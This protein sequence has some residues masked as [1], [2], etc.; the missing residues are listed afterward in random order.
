MVTFS[1]N[2]SEHINVI[3]LRQYAEKFLKDSY[4]IDLKIPVKRNNRLTRC[5][6]RYLSFSSGRPKTIEL[7]GR[8]IDH[9]HKDIVI[10]VL[11]HECI[12]HALHIIGKP[13]DDGQ[14]YF[15][16][17]LQ[18]HHSHSTNT[19]HVGKRNIL[20]CVSCNKE[21]ETG[22]KNVG[23]YIKN[24]ESVCCEDDFVHI[25]HTVSNGIERVR[26]ELLINN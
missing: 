24:Y 19:L 15:E 4:N 7:S 8:L 17:E 11:K 13:W 22:Q 16:R 14:P 9:G 21:I 23:N 3:R 1:K 26:T 6:G 25:G 12:H 20:K 10:S 5:L 2:R 18:K